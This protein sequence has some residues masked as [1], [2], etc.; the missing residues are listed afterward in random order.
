[1]A[2]KGKVKQRQQATEAVVRPET[3]AADGDE[4]KDFLKNIVMHRDLGNLLTMVQADKKKK[5]KQQKKQ[6]RLHT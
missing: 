3:A 1:M 6:P 2:P 5:K 4:R